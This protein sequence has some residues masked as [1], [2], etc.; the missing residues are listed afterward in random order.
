[1]FQIQVAHWNINLLKYWVK[2]QTLQ[3]SVTPLFKTMQPHQDSH[4]SGQMCHFPP[5]SSSKISEKGPMFLLDHILKAFVAITFWFRYQNL[6]RTAGLLSTEN[7][8]LKTIESNRHDAGYTHRMCCYTS[9]SQ[10]NIKEWVYGW[11]FTYR[12]QLVKSVGLTSTR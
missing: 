5:H 2:Q 4:T 10:I 9:R 7:P 3:I 1:M 11:K 8:H 12:L 6:F